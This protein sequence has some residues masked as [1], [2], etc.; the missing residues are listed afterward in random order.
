[1]IPALFDSVRCQQAQAYAAFAA[2][3][4]EAGAQI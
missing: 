1:M 4:L 2:D 3:L